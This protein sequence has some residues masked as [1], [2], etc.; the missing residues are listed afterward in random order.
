MKKVVIAVIIVGVFASCNTTKKNSNNDNTTQTSNSKTTTMSKKESAKALLASINKYDAEMGS[1]VLHPDYEQHNPFIA[2]KAEGLLSLYPAVEKAGL[3]VEPVLILE[4]GKY[5]VAFNRWHNAALF[6]HGC[7]EMVSFD[8]YTVNEDAKLTGHWDAMQCESVPNK[9]GRTLTGGIS[10]IVDLDKTEEN[11]TKVIEIFKIL[12]HGTP[13]EAMAAV[14]ANFLPDYKQHNPDGADGIEGFL[15]AQ[16]SGE[17]KPRWFFEKQH[18][19]IGEGNYVLSI[20]EGKHSGVHSIFYDLVRLE[21][22][23]IAE[24]WDVIQAIPT[25]GLANINTMFNFN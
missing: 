2:D 22:G 19:V 11:K 16:M 10:E 21:N 3:T 7:S 5:L 9:S 18:K 20:A 12:I 8:F 25:E 14:K 1:K 13:E 24:H 6:G 15:T 17:V 4:D 23:K